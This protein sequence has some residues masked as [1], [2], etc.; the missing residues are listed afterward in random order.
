MT[1][2]A[3]VRAKLIRDLGL[4]RAELVTQFG[5]EL[6]GLGGSQANN[7]ARPDSDID[8]AVRKVRP[9]HLGHVMDAQDW[10]ERQLERPVDLV[11]LDALPS[12]KRDV[13]NH[14]LMLLS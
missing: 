8:L 3:P 5:I 9:I 6:V 1:G 7:T 4:L 2:A 11:F 14:D 13:F 10:L 12:Y